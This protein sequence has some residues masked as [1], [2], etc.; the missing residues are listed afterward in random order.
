[1]SYVLKKIEAEGENY[2]SPHVFT[3]KIK[4]GSDPASDLIIS[5]AS[6]LPLHFELYSWGK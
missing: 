6:I 4:V 2:S 5:S 1:M 3:G